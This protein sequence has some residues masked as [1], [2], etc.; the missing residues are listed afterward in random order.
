MDQVFSNCLIS[1][2]YISNYFLW[3]SRVTWCFSFFLIFIYLYIFYFW[4]CWVFVSVRRPS[5]VAVSGGHSS[6]RCARLP[7]TVTASLAAEHRLQTR[8]LSSCGSRASLLRGMWDL[9]RPG[10][11]PVSPALAGR[12]STA[13][14]HNV[15]LI[16][17]HKAS[18]DIANMH[19]KCLPLWTSNK[20]KQLL[21]YLLN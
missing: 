8:R 16:V 1:K 14:P 13:V 12:F 9:P 3:N 17:Y 15:S 19:F 7:L 20:Y 5:L 18:C 21:Y 11:E 2:L 10:L 4:L 6:S